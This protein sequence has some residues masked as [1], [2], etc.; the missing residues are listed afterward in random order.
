RP[1][2]P[3]VEISGPYEAIVSESVARRLWPGQDPIGKRIRDSIPP[4]YVPGGGAWRTVVGVARETHLRTIR[5]TAP[6][7][8]LPWRQSYWQGSFAIRT[9]GNV[10]A[11]TPAIRAAAKEADPELGLWR[12][13]AMDQMLDEPLAQARLGAL[14]ESGIGQV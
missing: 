11:L 5:Q 1:W 2:R 6:T 4:D 12:A 8:Y 13:P 7:V 14:L 3:D 10:S 9:S